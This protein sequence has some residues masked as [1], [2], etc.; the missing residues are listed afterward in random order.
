MNS[1]VVAFKI[2][3]T[4]AVISCCPQAI[5]LKG[6]TLFVKL[7]KNRKINIFFS[8][9]NVKDNTLHISIRKILDNKTR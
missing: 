4:L 5:K 3:P 2:E 8:I 6:I 7:M 1:G 9:L